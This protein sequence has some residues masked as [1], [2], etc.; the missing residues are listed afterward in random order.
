MADRKG[1]KEGAAHLHSYLAL[2]RLRQEEN[3]LS[4]TRRP[5]LET[6][7]NNRK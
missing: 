2:Q 5:S 7:N 6:Q 3:L 4:Y 1:G